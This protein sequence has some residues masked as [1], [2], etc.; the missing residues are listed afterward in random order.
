MELHDIDNLPIVLYNIHGIPRKEDD[1]MIVAFAG[2]SNL[3]NKSEVEMLVRSAL[4]KYAAKNES[5][6]FYC[7]GYGDFDLLCAGVVARMKK[8]NT[9][10]KSLL[11]VPYMNKTPDEYGG[12]YDGTIYP[13]IENVPHRL[14][15]V[16]RNEWMV[17]EA[18]LVLAYVEFSFGGASRTLEYAKRKGKEIIDLYHVLQ[19]NKVDSH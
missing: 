8:Q 16:K 11:V 3:S 19:K 9:E 14:A 18:D 10:W 12:I 17:D 2:H 1:V 7:G 15:I 13:P 4:E 5:I 6:T